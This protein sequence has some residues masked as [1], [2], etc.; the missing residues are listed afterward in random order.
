LEACVRENELH[1]PVCN[2]SMGFNHICLQFQHYCICEMQ[3][4]A[5]LGHEW[6]LMRAG[7]TG[8]PSM[9]EWIR[10]NLPEGS[11]VGI[12][13]VRSSFC[14]RKALLCCNC[15]KLQIYAQAFLNGFKL[16]GLVRIVVCLCQPSW[17]L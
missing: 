10:D 8:V 15:C 4:E 13:P 9:S 2:C 1:A 14:N 12:D 7:T 16:F 3:A 5:Q 17:K 11:K 6:T